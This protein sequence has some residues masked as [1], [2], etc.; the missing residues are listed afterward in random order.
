MLK[1]KK[2]KAAKKRTKPGS[3]VK[4]PLRCKPKASKPRGKR[5]PYKPRLSKKALKAAGLPIPLSMQLQGSTYKAQRREIGK[6]TA[7]WYKRLAD[8]GMEDIEWLDAETGY[9]QNTPHLKRHDAGKMKH[10][11]PAS[12]EFYRL[13]AA[14]LQHN[15]WTATGHLAG[16]KLIWALYTDGVTYRKIRA[17]VSKKHGR[18]SLFYVHMRIH[19]LRALM[20]AWHREHPEGLLRPELEDAY[21]QEV[22]LREPEPVPSDA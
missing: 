10:A 22:L 7:E 12:F 17:E 1:S 15:V 3:R 13:C 6:M 20:Y 21:V 9:G 16:D 2:P 5:G 4:K 11:R 19:A 18:K 8:E 14:Y